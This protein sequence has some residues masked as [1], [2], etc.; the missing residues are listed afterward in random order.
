M[1]CLVKPAAAHRQNKALIT[2]AILHR[3]ITVL[4]SD[5]VSAAQG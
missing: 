2:A 5:S 3:G 4:W 1:C